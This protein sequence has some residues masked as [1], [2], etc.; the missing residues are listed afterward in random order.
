MPP[1]ARVTDMHVCPMVTP[2]VPPIPHVGGP[3]LPPGAPTVLIDFLPAATVTDM[4]T[5]VG[6]PDMIAMGSTGV[7]I[8]FL[9]AARLGDPTVHGGV[10]VLG[11]P[12]CIIGEV[13]A[14]SPG[15]VGLWGVVAGMAATAKSSPDNPSILGVGI[16]KAQT[17]AVPIVTEPK[18]VPSPLPGSAHN[19]VPPAGT[20]S[21]SK[22]T[23]SEIVCGLKVNSASITCHHG[24]PHKDGL[25]EVVGSLAGDTI[26]CKSQPIGGCGKHP[27]WEIGGYWSTEKVGANTSF[28]ARDFEALPTAELIFPVWLGDI[29]PHVYDVSVASCSGPS[30]SFEVKA[31]PSDAQEITIDVKAFLDTF[32]PAKDGVEDVVES[33]S[34]NRPEIEFL[35][36]SLQCAAQWAEIEKSNLAFYKWSV[37]G[38]FSPLLA[39]KIRL[40]LGPTA[41]P[42]PLSKYGNA[43]FFLE[44]KG[45]ITLSAEGGQLNPPD[46]EKGQFDLM[47]ETSLIFAIGG[48]VFMGKETDPYIK[49]EVSVQSGAKLE[50]KGRLEDLR[51][52][53]EGKLTVGGLHG[54]CVFHAFFY[55]KKY[56][57]TF[58]D[59]KEI[60]ASEDFQIF[61]SAPAAGLPVA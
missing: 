60:W 56:D 18:P 2:G 31:Y 43:M 22:S 25:L 45:E 34:G 58:T 17:S 39:A 40:P 47:S 9:P 21:R 59:D 44:V 46:S 41:I 38:G 52:I 15:A 50:L 11:S 20:S 57:C 7:F 51:P 37:S 3:I 42:P 24:R 27:L 30:Y 8:N 5:C 13:G 4:A 12:T 35:Q 32:K 28:N 23:E 26:D 36:G 54:V 48:S 49:A 1:A 6:P 33:L 19:M 53:G 14:P 16:A 10:I 55:D 61:G 29:E